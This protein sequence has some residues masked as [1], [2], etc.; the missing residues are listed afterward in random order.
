MRFLD[1]PRFR[2]ETE[3]GHKSPGM[4]I[5]P[6][7]V[8]VLL[9]APWLATGLELHIPGLGR[10]NLEFIRET[11]TPGAVESRTEGQ[12]TPDGDRTTLA[13]QE[14]QNP[15]E[16]D[17]AGG[18][19]ENQT[20]AAEADQTTKA[21]NEAVTGGATKKAEEEPT[22]TV[23]G[24]DKTA[25]AGNAEQSEAKKAETKKVEATT[26]AQA[27]PK[28]KPN[29]EDK[30]E[31]TAS[32]A[33]TSEAITEVTTIKDK[34][35]DTPNPGKNME[36]TTKQE[37]VTTTAKPESEAEEE[38]EED[39]DFDMSDVWDDVEDPPEEFGR[40]YDLDPKLLDSGNNSSDNDFQPKLELP[41]D[42]TK[43]MFFD[44]NNNETKAVAPDEGGFF[45][46]LKKFFSIGNLI[47]QLDTIPGKVQSLMD[48]F[49]QKKSS[50]L[51]SLREKMDGS[52]ESIGNKISEAFARMKPPKHEPNAQECLRSVQ[53][54]FKQYEAAL[55]GGIEPCLEKAQ[56]VLGKQEGAL[57]GAMGRFSRML[58]DMQG[59]AQKLEEAS[60]KEFVTSIFNVGSCTKNNIQSMIE[61]T[62]QPQMQRLSELIQR[63]GKALQGNMDATG[64]C[65]K[66]KLQ[67]SKFQKQQLDLIA[68]GKRCL[69]RRQ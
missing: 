56:S 11:T 17:E 46:R 18:K 13:G 69:E 58:S 61:Q 33:K 36:T 65:I 19:T 21:G 14:T 40:E 41:P 7:L 54:N 27:K 20:E 35:A 60:I 39:D 30:K 50:G 2:T 37:A 44:G 51:R 38:E 34:K 49:Q 67:L 15:G 9:C 55:Q 4:E 1:A 28:D 63:Q 12:G 23:K 3:R 66:R 8:V 25:Q 59:C 68:E 47:E 62:L 64:E 29:K 16:G 57:K 26:E 22:T 45:D 32:T 52:A 42:M 10:M 53:E 48:Q 31:T 6:L 5:I 43:D 24:N